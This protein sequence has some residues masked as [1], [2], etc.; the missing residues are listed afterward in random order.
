TPSSLAQYTIEGFQRTFFFGWVQRLATPEAGL[1]QGRI[2]LGR[3]RLIPF[4]TARGA[5]KV[6]SDSAVGPTQP[7]APD[8]LG[9]MQEGETLR[10]QRDLDGAISKFRQAI[11]GFQPH[12]TLSTSNFR[13]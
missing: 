8:Y 10:R 13:T 12:P 3:S 1:P 7:S 4:L 9:A 11:L 5:T 6:T 2:G